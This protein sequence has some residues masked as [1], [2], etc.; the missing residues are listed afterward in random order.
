MT[1]NQIEYIEHESQRLAVILRSQFQET[2]LHF[3]TPNKDP[4]QLAY[5]GYSKGKKI[6]PHVHN[7]VPRTIS[8]TQE[9]IF[10]RKGKVRVDLYS[11]DK[12]FQISR[13]LEQGD[14]I[15]LS[16]GGHGFEILEDSEIIEA[17]NG[18]YIGES[19]KTRF[20]GKT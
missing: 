14:C 1:E 7:E 10:I 11:K 16:E 4:M 8:V 20:N 18:P 2:G 19:D 17:K 9:I 6:S 3:F 5:F 13:I 12:T 15:L